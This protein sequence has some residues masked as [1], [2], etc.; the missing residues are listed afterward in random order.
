MENHADKQSL[1]M[2]YR[3]PGFRV[4]ARIDSYEV[5]RLA[6]VI[7]LDRHQKKRYAADAARRTTVSMTES[8]IAPATSIAAIA[9]SI[10]TSRCGGW[11]ARGAAA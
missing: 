3:V 7:T 11:P 9:K 1:L 10:W 5:K 8:G 4:R 6:F 2:A